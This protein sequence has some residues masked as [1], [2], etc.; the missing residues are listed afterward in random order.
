M[1]KLRYYYGAMNSMKSATLL[2]KAHQFE[3]AGCKV[4]LFKPAFDDRD[5]GEVRSRAIQYGRECIVF[6]KDT[7]LI[8]LMY[9][10]KYKEICEE[11]RVVLFFDEIN[12][13]TKEQIRQ[14]WELSKYYNIDVFC[15]GLKM[16]YKNRLF[17]ASE[18]LLIL[19]DTSEEIKSMCSR[20]KNKATTHLRLIN[21][22]AVFEGEN[23]ITGDISG[24]EKYLS[25]CQVCYDKELKGEK[26][27]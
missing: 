18:E 1:K 25:V 12:F 27:E 23:H 6:D 9:T 5:F 22:K 26:Y 20:C 24:E 19:A 3:Q 21:G 10:K 13:M 14:L 2:L 17:E 7:D 4:F 16:N 15:Y 8:Q 11:D